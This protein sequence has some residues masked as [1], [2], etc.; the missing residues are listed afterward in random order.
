M[1]GPLRLSLP[2][3]AAGLGGFTS[4]RPGGVSPGPYASLNLGLN[5]EDEPAAVLENRRLALQGA[6]LDPLQAVYLQQVHGARIAEAGPQ[7]AGRGA[8]SWEQALPACDAVFTRRRG[9][10]LA[11][12]HA[13]CLAV[14]L[15]DPEAGLLGLAHAGWRGA[16][17]GLPGLLAG[18]LLALGASAGRLRAALSPCLG[19]AHL[20]LGEEQHRLFSAAFPRSRAFLSSLRAGHCYLDLWTC[21]RVQLLEAG[22][23]PEA[24]Q[25]QELDTASHPELFFSHRRDQG[26]TGRMMTYA[27]LK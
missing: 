14:V 21:A 20:E 8:L 3:E 18:R 6:G 19:P 16:L 5:T 22:L 1:H 15:A 13:D 2:W 11:V 17:A 12:G 26:R 23:A 25:G 27:Y 24:I 9:L 4:T 7:E 10:V